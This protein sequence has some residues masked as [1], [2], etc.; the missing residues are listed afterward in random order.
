[1][2][3]LDSL[4]YVLALIVLVSAP[5]ALCF[6]LIVHP[7]IDFWRRLGAGWTF[8]LVAPLLVALGGA[9]FLLRE[10]LLGVEF[11]TRSVLVALGGIC[12][13]IALII[14][15][16][17]RRHLTLR[18]ITGLPELAREGA[19]G[20]LLTQGIYARIRHP[21]YVEVMLGLLGWALFTNYLALYLL[22]ALLVPL[23]YL[24]VVLEE[25]ELRDRFGAEY[26]DYCRSV[27][28]FLPR[29][30]LRS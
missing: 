9:L 22:V 2:T 15:V 1:V 20:T 28:R 26:E 13:A 4:R 3:S 23:I 5:P 10:S 12:V 7:F 25:R 8:A 6:W 30:R 17:C 11:G 29:L 14:A 24:V 18:I 27:P 16:L 19:A 21:R